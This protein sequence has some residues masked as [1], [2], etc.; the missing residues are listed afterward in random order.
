[1][2]EMLDWMCS[3]MKPCLDASLDLFH[4]VP[5]TFLI[6]K[7]P[8]TRFWASVTKESVHVCAN[9]FRMQRQRGQCFQPFAVCQRVISTS[10]YLTG[11]STF[12]TI[13]LFKS[14]SAP[15]T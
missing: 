14:S 4:G 1:M 13:T 12:S 2:L 10:T 11:V 5:P 7:K 6:S 15:G 3:A 9:S 8:P